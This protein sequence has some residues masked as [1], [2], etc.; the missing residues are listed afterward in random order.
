MFIRFFKF[1]SPSAYIFL[2][3][4]AIAI[5]LGAMAS[6]T[7]F[8]DKHVMPLFYLVSQLIKTPWLSCLI[9]FLFIV[10]EAFLLNFIVNENEILN[11]QSFLPALLY[12][13]FMS[14][15]SNLL[16]LHPLVFSNLF[17]L[18]AI[19]KLISS[20]RKDVV[21]SQAFD[22]GFLISIASLFY[23]PSI[24]FLLLLVVGFILFRPFNWREWMISFLGA[25]VPYLFVLMYYFWN[26]SLSTFFYDTILFPLLSYKTRMEISESFYF[27]IVIAL[28]IIFFSFV[29]LMG[30]LTGGSQKSKKGIVLFVWT[31][32]FSGLS[33]FLAPE[34]S[35]IT[36]SVSAIPLSV[37]CANYFLNLKKGWFAEML[38]LLFIGSIFYNLIEYFF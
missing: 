25:V 11:K 22:A 32:I 34:I 3:L 19:N 2:P 14:N 18:F 21:F 5:W 29:K 24:I 38:F 12:L 33:I 20:Y 10:A 30:G 8:S 6:T 28:I 13:V 9:A 36:L 35:T 4:I 27:T 31:L 17:I 7:V 1:N 15:N 37:F 16:V 26:N 23:F